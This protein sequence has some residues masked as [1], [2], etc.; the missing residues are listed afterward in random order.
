MSSKKSLFT[1]SSG[2]LFEPKFT[3]GTRKSSAYLADQQRNS[4]D[5]SNLLDTN[6]NSTSSFRYGD[7]KHLVSTQQVRTDF[8]KFENHTFFHSAIANVNETFDRIVNFYPFEGSRKE[9]EI[10]E[11][12]LTG[13]EKYVLDSFPKN[14]GYLNF[15]GT[16]PSES[17]DNGT[18]IEVLDRSGASIKAISNKIDGKKVLDPLTSSFSFEFW[19]KP[20][21]YSNDN[22]IVFQKYKTLANNLT[23]ALTKSDSTDSCNIHF[24]ITS[25]SNYAVV[26][27]SIAK[28]SF[29][30]VSAMYDGKGDRKLKLLINEN[31]HTSS[32]QVS[33]DNLDYDANSLFIGKGVDARMGS[34]IFSVKQSFSGSIDDIRYFHKINLEKDIKQNKYRS[35]FPPEKSVDDSLKLYLKFN[36]PSGDYIGNDIALDSSGNSLHSRISNYIASYSRNT[37]SDNPVLSEQLKRNPVLFPSYEPVN[38]LNID[39]LSSASN[40][41]NYNPNIITKLVPNHYFEQGTN[42]RDFTEEIDKIGQNFKS[43]SDNNIGKNISDIPPPQVLMKLLFTY[44]KFFDELKIYIDT[45]TS[46]R[47]TLYNEFDT[48]PDALL[49][50]KAKLT[51]THL[52]QLFKHANIAQFFSGI[53]LGREKSRSVNSLETIQKEIWR[54]YIS[55]APRVNLKRGTL[56]AVRSVFRNAG[57]EPDNIFNLREF[58]GSKEKSLDSSRELKRDV[59]NFLSFTGSYGKQTTGTDFQGYPTDS[60]IPKIKSNFLSASRI[61][62]G[63]PEIAGTFVNKDSKNIHG[64]SNNT[65]DGL[66]TSGSFT[67][68]GLYKWNKGYKNVP[69]SLIRLHVTGT[70]A[71]SSREGIIANV[72]GDNESINL[73]LRDSVTEDSTLNLYLTGV[74]VFDKDVWYV[75]FGKKDAHDLNLAYTGSYFLRAAKQENGAIIEEYATSSIRMNKSD[76]VLKNISAYNTKGAFLVIGSQSFGE[77]STYFLNDANGSNASP[78]NSVYTSFSG[79][80]A[81]PRFFSKALSDKEWKSHAKNY[82]SYGVDNPS[83]NYNFSNQT[84]GSFERLVLQTDAKQHTTA[85]DA[86]GNIRLFDFTKNSLHFEGSNFKPS[87]LVTKPQRVNYE[88]LSDKFDINFS[89]EKVRVRSF[90]NIENIETNYFSSIAPVTKILP[91]EESLDDNRFS[92]D[93]SVMKALNEHILLIFS[94]FT[95]LEDIYGAPNNIFAEHYPGANSLREIYFN[96]LL[97]KIDLQRYRELF[98]WID[99]TFTQSVFKVLPRSTNFLG[100]NFIY[101]SHVLERNRMRYLS[102]EI[103]MKALQRDPTRGDIFLSQFVT[104]IRKF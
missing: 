67:Y 15:S 42:F 55:E 73:Y 3:R 43:I 11:D 14:V 20:A 2:V 81:N 75:S 84:T 22:Q 78:A 8:S 38:V 62:I 51:N 72:V 9:I 59:F 31:F 58:G 46:Y 47:H 39:L 45:I 29:S 91:S 65:S 12:G 30:H 26:T 4:Y 50:E 54:R 103:Y 99:N 93:M 41:D 88:V 98:K 95:H 28:G 23:L 44:A 85:S 40:Y 25:G 68:E 87:S 5:L 18:Y 63:S 64:I 82:R 71:P 35:F 13:F 86:G 33:F 27:G 80:I 79:L 97:E 77:T 101:E 92:I 7:K 57:I 48:T 74:N 89:R 100:I 90:Q 34:N 70:S 16:Q 96:N 102:D 69:E 49:E 32:E 52:P 24:A 21:G 37:G 36:S 61:Q 53:D 1:R 10:Y 60:G 19:M 66:L 56:D 76:S 17:I 83:K 6:L 94:D 104:K